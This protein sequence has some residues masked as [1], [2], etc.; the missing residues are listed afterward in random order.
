MHVELDRLRKDLKQKIFVGEPGGETFVAA[1]PE[2]R[3]ETLRAQSHDRA[4]VPE[5]RRRPSKKG[6]TTFE[7]Y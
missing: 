3:I 1:T 7:D 4:P 6:Q 2:K 5:S